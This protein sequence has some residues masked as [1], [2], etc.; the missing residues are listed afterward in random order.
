F[1]WLGLAAMRTGRLPHRVAQPNHVGVLVGD[2]LLWLFAL[3][4]AT[5]PVL[6]SRSQEVSLW[7]NSVPTSVSGALSALFT[8]LAPPLN[9]YPAPFLN[10]ILLPFLPLTL[11]VLLFNLDR[12]QGWLI[13]SWLGSVLLT[14]IVADPR[15]LRWEILLP[16]APAIAVAVAFTIDRLRVSLIASSGGWIQQFLAY[17]L[18]GML[19]WVAFHNLT[20]QATFLVSQSDRT[21]AFGYALRALPADQPVIVQLPATEGGLTAATAA[22]TLP[23]RFLTNERVT[24]DNSIRFVDT[25]PAGLAPGTAI[26]FF[27]EATATQ[28]MLRATYPAGTL[29]VQRDRLANPVISLYLIPPV[30]E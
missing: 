23:L 17:S 28:Q 30:V 11:G 4:V 25:V 9:L 21:S 19:L 22:M 27:P 10:P 13:G 8:N 14:A 29:H 18:L 2:L 16:L 24:T 15:L 5:A 7:I 6:L 20:T 3:Y 1:W 26:L 12:R